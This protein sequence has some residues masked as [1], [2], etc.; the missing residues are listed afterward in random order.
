MKNRARSGGA[1][2]V[3]IPDGVA[4]MTAGFNSALGPI[5]YASHDDPMPPVRPL[6]VPSFLLRR[7]SESRPLAVGPDDYDVIGKDGE[8]IGRIVRTATGPAGKAWMWSV[9]TRRNGE[10]P[11]LGYEAT[12][13]AAMQAFAKAWH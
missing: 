9:A 7:S 5:P 1:V 8:I 4:L 12:R 6:E 11:V 10:G 13:E 2:S 3:T